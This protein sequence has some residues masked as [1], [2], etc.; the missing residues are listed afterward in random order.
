MEAARSIRE[1]VSR[2]SLLR[3][4]AHA[5][6]EVLHALAEVKRVQARRFSGTYADL[7]S[8]GPY[9]AASSFFLQ[10]LYSDKDYAER[11]EQFARIAG[12][13]ERF[14]P[15]A[16]VETAV[17]LANLHALTEDLDQAM[18]EAWTR[19]GP[20]LPIGDASRYVDAWRDVGRRTDRESQLSV[21]LDIG[22]R[23]A[24]LTR[25]P[26][27]RTL[28]RMMRGPA[29]AAGLSSLQRFLETGFDTFAAMA[30]QP[31]GAEEFLQTIHR[32]EAALI[33]MLFDG[34]VVACE[35]ELGA[36]LGQAR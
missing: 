5:R 4:A 22:A 31:G 30:K 23:M 16:V 12:A 10:E 32:R 13:I 19:R 36:T 15:S 14:F 6:P 17:A 29:T 1:A 28:L 21:V 18:G 7:L 8:Q 20:E 33:Q 27:L 11:D 35:T 3:Q 2:V 34:P 24:R 9:V 26:G 25:T